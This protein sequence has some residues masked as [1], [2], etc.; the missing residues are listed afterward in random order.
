MVAICIGDFIQISVRFCTGKCDFCWRNQHFRCSYV[1]GL[2]VGGVSTQLSAKSYVETTDAHV[3]YPST[4]FR[5]VI[6]ICQSL[7]LE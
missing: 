6:D 5:R 4:S 2:R 3:A 7:L 1:F